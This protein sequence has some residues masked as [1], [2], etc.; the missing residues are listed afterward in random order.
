MAKI[1]KDVA[2]EDFEKWLDYK[3]ISDRLREKN[4]D[5]EET[6]IGAIEDGLL[7]VNEDMTLTQRLQFPTE[8]DSPITEL[9]YK[10]R[11]KMF[12][13]ENAVKG[14]K[15]TDADGRMRGYIQQLTGAPKGV[16][17]KLEAGDDVQIAQ[18]I[19]FYFL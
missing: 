15:P 17:Q 3:R 19:A 9:K 11:L 12:E 13:K 8:G 5:S 2:T 4:Q 10:P 14:I 1:S 7:T 6:L 16:I 18:A